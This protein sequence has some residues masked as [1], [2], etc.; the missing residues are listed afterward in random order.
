MPLACPVQAWMPTP[1]PGPNTTPRRGPNVEEFSGGEVWVR[2]TTVVR[3]ANRGR[4]AQASNRPQLVLSEFG[5]E[6]LNLVVS[7]FEI[8]G[9][10]ALQIVTQ[11]TKITH[12]SPANRTL[13]GVVR[14]KAFRG[15]G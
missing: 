2:R 3:H 5:A 15:L 4:A 7:Q 10:N 13:N 6:C 1:R 9:R 8:G 11:A 14:L 12:A